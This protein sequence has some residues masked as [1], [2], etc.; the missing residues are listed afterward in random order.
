[1]PFLPNLDAITAMGINPVTGLPYK[2]GAPAG[3]EYNLKPNIKTNLRIIDEQDAINRFK[4][5]GLEE[6]GITPQLLERILYYRGSGMFF[7]LQD[8]YYFLPYALDGN[9]DVYSRMLGVTPVPFGGS[10][11]TNDGD[12][13]KP[14]IQGLKRIPIYSKLDSKDTEV[15]CV[16]LNDY[17]PQLSQKIIPR[18]QLSEAWLDFESDMIP[19]TRTALLNATGVSAIRVNSEDEQSNVDAASR[20]V[21]RA[22]LVGQKWIPIVGQI[23][24]QDLTSGGVQRAEDFLMAMQSVDNLRLSTHGLTNGGIFQKKT[25]VLQDEEDI[26]QGKAGIVMTD[27]LENRKIFCELVNELFGLNIACEQNVFEDLPEDGYEETNTE[28]DN[29][30]LISE[31]VIE[32]E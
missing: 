8:K 15:N 1:M 27:C 18:S 19:F 24:F 13:V 17:T 23:D 2:M 22:A 26:N 30:E 31:T 20:S 25:H 3:L 16:L 32:E 9:I 7:R 6:T 28:E 4:W 21:N 14:W 12:K 10:A 11:T 29:G 5:T